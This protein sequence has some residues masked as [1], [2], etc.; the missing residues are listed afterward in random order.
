MMARSWKV[1]S[2][3]RDSLGSRG[4]YHG[5]DRLIVFL[6]ADDDDDDGVLVMRLAFTETS[7][8]TD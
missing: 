5:E 7:G 1:G 2:E 8:D 3:A 4:N 6:V